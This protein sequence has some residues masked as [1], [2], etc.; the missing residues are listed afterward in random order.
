MHERRV[1]PFDGA[2]RSVAESATVA[3][4]MHE[5]RVAPLDGVQRSSEESVHERRI[6]PLDGAQ[7]SGVRY[8]AVQ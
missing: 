2:Q 6:A 8:Q 7:R 3:E 4:S 5:R 1:A